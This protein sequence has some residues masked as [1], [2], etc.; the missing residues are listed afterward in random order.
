MYAVLKS[1]RNELG[2]FA[3]Y[4]E[5]RLR[6]SLALARIERMPMKQADILDVGHELRY[7][8][9]ES[10]FAETIQSESSESK[11][12]GASKRSMTSSLVRYGEPEDIEEALAEQYPRYRWAFPWKRY[13][14]IG[15]GWV[16]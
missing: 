13:V 10:L 9:V 6:C 12:R 15:A 3:A 4:L 11:R 14:I 2:F 7:A 16:D 5:D 1:R 8:D